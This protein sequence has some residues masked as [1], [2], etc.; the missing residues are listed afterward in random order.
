MAINNLQDMLILHRYLIQGEVQEADAPYYAAYLAKEFGVVVNAPLLLCEDNVRAIADLFCHDVPDSFYANPQDTAFYS[1]Q[2]LYV[3][4]LISYIKI[5]MCGVNAEDPAVFAKVPVFD[6]VLPTY[7]KNKEKVVRT[8]S[9]IDRDAAEKYAKG[10]FDGYCAYT[11]PWSMSD[12][13]EITY[14]VDNGYYTGQKIA[15]KDNI[16]FL[17]KMYGSEEFAKML[18]YKDVVKMSVSLLGEKHELV[19]DRKVCALLSLAVKNARP[20]VLSKKQSKY[21]N[22]LIKKTGA[23]VPP[24]NNSDSPYA[25]AKKFIADGDV[26][27]A[28]KFLASNGALFLRNLF[29][30]LSRAKTD[31][32]VDEI[33]A[34]L[35]INKP[36]VGMQIIYM[37]S[38]YTDECRRFVFYKN[39]TKI[40]HEE[41]KEESEKRRSRVELS[42]RK[43]VEAAVV[44]GI[45]K[46]YASRPSIGRIYIADVFRKVGVPINTATCG[47]GLDVLPTGSRLPIKGDYLRA[48]CYWEKTYDMDLSAVFYDG[49]SKT[50]ILYWGT[51]D[52][53]PFGDSALTSGDARGKDG[54]EYVDFKIKEL[55]EKGWKYG[56]VFVNSFG[57]LFN[58]G[59]VYCGYQDKDDLKTKAWAPDN[60]A[61]KIS[62]KGDSRQFAAFAL[63]LQ[64]R[65]V[66]VLNTLIGNGNQ[67]VDGNSVYAFKP[68]LNPDVLDT[69]SM[70]TLL[71][72]CG[73]IVDDPA[74]AE[75]VFDPDYVGKDGQKVIRPWDVQLL[76]PYIM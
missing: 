55:L 68:Y 57:G 40:M 5:E 41:S 37:L 46:Y 1:E 42:V 18:D 9:I 32:E 20:C 74:D 12:Y 56:V 53:K 58:D 28:A 61:M 54:A 7:G 50:N 47:K 24:T 21:F 6:K 22:K 39:G 31:E 27:G 17:L 3:E 14:F 33:L 34:L 30:L 43:K 45:K 76:V 16:I 15:C 65:E 73:E 8:F 48:F 52:F 63:D 26:I 69:F 67:V 36:I 66:I 19:I 49:E 11:R 13:G 2:E 38:G 51:Y 25:I 23:D 44:S 29:W 72:L 71:S 64:R 59:E 4:Q 70:H 35:E 10:L 75:T 60:I 62:V